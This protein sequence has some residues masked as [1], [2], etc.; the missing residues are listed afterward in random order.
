M[1]DRGWPQVAAGS[2][3]ILYPLFFILVFLR[4]VKLVRGAV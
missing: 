2:R 3:A 1:K 4:Q